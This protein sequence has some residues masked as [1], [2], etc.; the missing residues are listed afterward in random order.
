MKNYTLK[1]VLL[2]L[3][4]LVLTTGF[5]SCHV[6][7]N[8]HK[9]GVVKRKDIPPGHLKKMNGSKSAKKYAPGHGKK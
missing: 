6:Y 2:G 3:L 1:K 5:S 8:N 7:H 4:T 9:K